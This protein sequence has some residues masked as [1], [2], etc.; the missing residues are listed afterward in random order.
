[1]APAEPAGSESLARGTRLALLVSVDALVVAVLVSLVILPS[2]GVFVALLPAGLF[3]APLLAAL[4]VRPFVP[5]ALRHPWLIH[6]VLWGTAGV[7]TFYLGG[8]ALSNR[9]DPNLAVVIGLFAALF[10]GVSWGAWLGTRPR[11]G[12]AGP[13]PQ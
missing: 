7:G 1:M 6:V 4:L 12:S 10:G 9:H 5:R 11:H 2:E 13:R 8:Q 3:A